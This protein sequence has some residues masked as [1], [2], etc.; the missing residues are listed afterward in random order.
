MNS[1]Q[2]SKL[3]RLL[4]PD[5]CPLCNKL[6]EPDEL[7]CK[8]CTQL[9][10]SKRSPII[11]GAMGYRCVSSFLYDG[12]VR[13][14]IVRLKFYRGTQHADRI[15]ALLNEDICKVYNAY[16]FDLITAVPMHPNDLKKRG[17]N[18]SRLIAQSLS[19]Q[20]GIPY[21]DTLI[22][23]KRTGPQHRLK[24]TERLNNL[25]GAFVPIDNA[26]VRGKSIL[27]IDDVITSGAT[28]GQCC[29]T[30]NGTK[31]ALICCATVAAAQQ[32]YDSA[33]II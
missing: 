19:R 1:K 12:M 15:A 33:A 22:K 6:I 14:M 18:Q 4:F 32:A 13:R 31:P 5:R 25:S 11:G 27:I 16:H 30:L 7:V 23:I 21:C 26:V 29:R 2:Y 9:L 3:A 8:T 20:T 10:R 17:Y 28:L 24:R